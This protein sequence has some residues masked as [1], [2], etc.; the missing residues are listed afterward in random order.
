MKLSYLV[1][2]WTL[3]ILIL[4]S[5]AC[6][7]LIMFC[8]DHPNAPDEGHISV[9]GTAIAN[10]G[11]VPVSAWLRLSEK[12]GVSLEGGI[13]PPPEWAVLDSDSEPVIERVQ[14]NAWDRPSWRIT[15]HP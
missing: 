8:I 5:G 4:V 10:F 14:V 2:R 3:L 1:G 12:S 15:F 13:L 11:A 6:G 9:G 7:A